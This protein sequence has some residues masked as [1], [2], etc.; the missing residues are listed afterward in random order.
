MS[1]IL[2]VGGDVANSGTGKQSKERIQKKRKNKE[3]EKM[4]PEGLL[5]EQAVGSYNC[6]LPMR[7]ENHERRLA[8][9]FLQSGKDTRNF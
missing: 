7:S 5:V 6:A 4:F 9:M 2:S 1:A 3:G 8:C